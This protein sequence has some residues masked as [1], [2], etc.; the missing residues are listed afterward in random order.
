MIT[1][2][3]QSLL[4]KKGEMMKN[5]LYFGFLVLAFAWSFLVDADSDFLKGFGY[6]TVIINTLGLILLFGLLMF[7]VEVLPDIH[8][9]LNGE[10][11]D[12]ELIKQAT[13]TDKSHII[14]I[15]NSIKVLAYTL[16]AI[17]VFTKLF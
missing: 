7:L 8:R 4:N 5:I 13:L 15:G 1:G 11:T 3:L 10:K 6:S 17:A 14:Y 12:A 2:Y 9:R 16:L